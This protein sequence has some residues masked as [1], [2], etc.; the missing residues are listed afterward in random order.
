M[1]GERGHSGRLVAFVSA[2]VLFLIVIKRS[3]MKD[4]AP[5]VSFTFKLIIHRDVSKGVTVIASLLSA[6]GFVLFAVTAYLLVIHILHGVS[7]EEPKRKRNTMVIYH[8][9]HLDDLIGL[10]G[11]DKS[12]E[13]G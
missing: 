9:H 5:A 13:S 11:C 1:G 6:P 4:T 2:H 8:I 10:G 3:Q 7:P 12:R